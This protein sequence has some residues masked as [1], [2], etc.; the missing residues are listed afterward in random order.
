[1]LGLVWRY[2]RLSG[3]DVTA[4]VEFVH[5]NEKALSVIDRVRQASYGIGKAKPVKKKVKEPS[6]PLSESAFDPF[7]DQIA[8]YFI[9]KRHLT[10][11][12][13]RAWGL[14]D[15]PRRQRAQIPVRDIDGV[16]WGMTGRLYA[17]YCQCGNPLSD[18]MFD[19][20]KKCPQCG[21]KKPPKYMHSKGLDKN[22]LLFGEHM[23]DRALDVVYVVE[24]HL[25]AIWLWQLGYRNVVAV[26]GSTLS[27]VQANKLV[28]WF[29]LVI[30]V[31]DGDKAGYEMVHGKEHYV[32]VKKLLDGRVSLL[33]KEL[34][35][36]LDPGALS[37]EQAR[38]YIG[39]PTVVDN[40]VVV[41]YKN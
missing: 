7:R 12:T 30:V 22:L 4:L 8:G 15:N 9:H 41:G 34:P 20:I 3:E 10:E 25:D 29:N 23:I 31:P 1:M 16:L 18:L 13:I 38:T 21:R 35:D 14:G 17:E 27:D 11:E 28:E 37:A 26:M 39:E 6:K 24:G 33:T 5:K 40:R 19:V 2:A 32:G 36:G